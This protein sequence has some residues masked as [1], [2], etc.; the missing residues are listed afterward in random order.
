M[1]CL[2]CPF[3][4][5]QFHPADGYWGGDRTD[6]HCDIYGPVYVEIN[7]KKR[8]PVGIASDGKNGIDFHDKIG[9]TGDCFCQDKL[10]AKLKDLLKKAEG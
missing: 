1:K 10:I 6:Y 4:K 7:G 2:E 5:G 8:G 3:L 9:Y